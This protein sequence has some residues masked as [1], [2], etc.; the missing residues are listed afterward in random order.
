MSSLEEPIKIGTI[1]GKATPFGFTI[2]LAMPITRTAFLS[3][4]HEEKTFILSVQNVWND[5][6]GSFAQVRVIGER[7]YHSI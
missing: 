7:A 3:T 5:K 2:N 6:K 4:I 1:E